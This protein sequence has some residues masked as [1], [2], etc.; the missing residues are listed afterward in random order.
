MPRCSICKHAGDDHFSVILYDEDD[1]EDD[2]VFPCA[3]C[4]CT[5]Y[6]PELYWEPVDRLN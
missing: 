6:D 1:N 2:E 5:D 3:L 4:L